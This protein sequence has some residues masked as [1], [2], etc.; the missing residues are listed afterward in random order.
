MDY[1]KKNISLA[2]DMS[3]YLDAIKVFIIQDVMRININEV[4][5]CEI[6]G[7]S[8]EVSKEQSRPLNRVIFN[9]TSQGGY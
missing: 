2:K 7:P 6:P 5:N 4:S 3:I 8:I 1:L 9:E